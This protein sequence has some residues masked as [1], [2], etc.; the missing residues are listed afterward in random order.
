MKNEHNWYNAYIIIFFI[1]VLAGSSNWTTC[2]SMHISTIF[3]LTEPNINT[4]LQTDAI[5]QV[6]GI[7]L[8]TLFYS[9]FS[10]VLTLTLRYSVI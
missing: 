8:F 6:V 1:C 5:D 3:S 7:V 2:F 10:E 4:N 9:F